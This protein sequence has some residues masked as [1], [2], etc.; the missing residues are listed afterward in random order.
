MNTISLSMEDFNAMFQGNIGTSLPLYCVARRI[1]HEI[2][3]LV[4]IGYRAVYDR[5]TSNFHVATQD[6]IVTIKI[7]EMYPFVAPPH[8][9]YD[10]GQVLLHDPKTEQCPDIKS[11]S[12]LSWPTKTDGRDKIV[13]LHRNWAP[14]ICIYEWVQVCPALFK[15]ELS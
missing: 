13:Y 12:T 15:R 3:R 11:I 1:R 14:Q 8:L 9:E 4:D 5:E 6:G 10:G 7:P 2:K